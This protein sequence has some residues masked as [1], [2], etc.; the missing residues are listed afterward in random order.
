M[1][2][3]EIT[4]VQTTLGEAIQRINEQSAGQEG[5]TL[6]QATVICQHLL[7]SPDPP[8]LGFFQ[9]ADMNRDETCGHQAWCK[10][11]DDR[12][13]SQGDWTDEVMEFVRP[14]IVCL[15]DYLKRQA[16][17]SFSLWARLKARWMLWHMAQRPSQES[18]VTHSCQTAQLIDEYTEAIRI[19]P[20]DPGAYNTRG[21][22]YAEKG[23][24]DRAIADFTEAIRRD[25][26]AT[27]A[28]NNRG[29][30]YES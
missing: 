3:D 22:R 18:V 26:N 24:Y 29:N 15:E 1:S 10:R 11:C 20:A 8:R 7:R 27:I 25:P 14:T 16:V 17:H 19:N 28:L 6:S 9:P 2:H 13:V 12:A 4:Q 23:D 21:T 30:S 5:E